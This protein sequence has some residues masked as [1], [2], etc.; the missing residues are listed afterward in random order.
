[1]NEKTIV[2]KPLRLPFLDGMRGWAALFVVLHHLHQEITYRSDLPSIFLKTTKWL[3]LGHFAV[4]VFIVLSG[5]S[6]MLPVVRSNN[7]H[8][9]RG[10]I[11]YIQRR[12]RRIL[13]PYFAA[14]LFSLLIFILF[15]QLLK[16]SQW[17]SDFEIPV[18]KSDI[19][20]SHFLLVHNLN[21]NWAL[22]INS[23]MWSVA[24]EW[25]IYFFFPLLLLPIWRRLGD[26]AVIFSGLALG[27]ALCYLFP[28]TVSA[29]PWYLGLF[30]MGMTAANIGFS[31]KPSIIKWRIKV[32]WAALC[33]L[34]GGI[35][36]TLIKTLVA[37]WI[38]DIFAGFATMCLIIYCSR[39]IT[40][41]IPSRR[42]I[43]L[44]FMETP[45]AI[46]IST[47][48]YSLYLLHSPLLSLSHLWL[49]S[50]TSSPILRIIVLPIIFLPLA[51][52]AAY[53][54]HLIFEKPFLQNY[55]SAKINNESR[56]TYLKKVL[57]S[58]RKYSDKQ[59]NQ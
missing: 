50:F 12:A 55:K 30:A 14:L 53:I 8:L 34:C 19:L 16:P 44:K 35:L 2:S 43:I 6:L 25:Q 59:P 29:T 39:Y 7:N 3:Q 11:D 49:R 54:F 48:S 47:F 17:R 15:P 38:C 41:T 32:P 28:S 36:A 22:K 20:I 5:Y 33:L 9:P 13:P 18:F 27:L 4:A 56:A 52:S 45:G 21:T 42:P 58:L 1:M 10:I 40:D 26:V 23:P 46:A 37:L 51:F 24:T 31:N 57:L